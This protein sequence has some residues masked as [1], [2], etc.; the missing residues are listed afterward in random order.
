MADDSLD[1]L[2]NNGPQSRESFGRW[3]NSFIGDSN[4]ALE[5]PS[6]GAMVTLEHEPFH[7]LSNMPEQVFNITEVS[8]TWAYSSEKT[9]VYFGLTGMDDMK[10]RYHV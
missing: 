9:K 5:D 1:A 3:M 6:Y 8:P 7:P 10:R 2:L 4:G